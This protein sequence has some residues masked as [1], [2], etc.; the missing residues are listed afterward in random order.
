MEMFCKNRIFRPLGMSSTRIIS[1]SDIIMHRSGGYRLAKG[2]LKN[3]DWVSPTLNTTADGALY[4]NVL[5][6]AKWDASL[7]TT[8]LLSQSSLDQIWSPVKLN[9]GHDL[10]LRLR[11]VAHNVEEWTSGCGA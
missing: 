4:T 11:L 5:D 2:E 1:E 9:N 7:Y 3:Q 8:K 10:S 6:L